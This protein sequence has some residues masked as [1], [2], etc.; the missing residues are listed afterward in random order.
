MAV[1]KNKI[2]AEATKHVQK[3]AFDKAIHAYR[4]ILAADAK[5]VRV[6]LKVAELQQKKGDARAAVEAYDKVAQTYAEQGFF[7]KAVAVYK[8]IVKLAPDDVRVN[9]QLAAL[10]QQLG[11]MSDAMAQFQAMAAAY[12]KA[13]D[14]A[15]LTDVLKRMVELDPENIASSIKLGEL[16]AR[17]RQTA[18]ALECFRRAAD[19]LKKHNRADEYVKVADRIAALSPDDFGLARELANIYL[20]KGDTKRAL[21]KLQLCFKADPKDVDTLHLLAQA[22]RDLGQISKTLSVYKELARVHEDR[23]RPQEAQA[24]WRKVQE[25]SPADEDALAALGSAART[26]RPPH[27]VAPAR[28]APSAAPPAAR[29]PPPPI[30][31][32][33]RPPPARPAPAPVDAPPP[34][35]GSEVIPKLM[36]ETDVYVKYG[37]IPK[38]L[39]HLQKLLAIDPGYAPAHEKARELHLSAG[40]EQEAAEAGARAVRAFAARGDLDRAREAVSRLAQIAPDWPELGALSAAVG[41]TEEVDLAVEGEEVVIVAGDVA[42]EPDLDDDAL[43]LAAAAAGDEE[44]IDEEVVVD[45][46]ASEAQEAPAPSV[47]GAP[48]PPAPAPPRAAAP[49]AAPRGAPSRPARAAPEPEREPEPDDEEVDLSDE[50]EEADFFVQQGLLDDAREAL[51]NLLAFYPRHSVLEAKLAE[52]ERRGRAAPAQAPPPAEAAD[53]SF[54]IARELAEMGGGSAA[55][56]EE[57]FQYSVED[58]FNQFKKGIEQTVKAEDSATHYDLGIAYKEMGLVD[59]AIHEFETALAGKD[60][61]REVDCLSMIGLCHLSK[62]DGAGAIAAFRRAL[63]S[64]RLTRDAAKAIHFDLAAAYEERGD[65]E[66]A[67]YYFQRVAKADA[68]FRAVAERVAALG[69]GAGRAPPDDQPRAPAASGGRSPPPQIPRASPGKKNIGYL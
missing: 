1:D 3:G 62:G 15:R 11:L 16:Y 59:D 9:E 29:P 64:D 41:G 6:L 37:L 48:P 21:A 60:R 40:H 45:E 8:Q 44:V 28:G 26:A 27:P 68:A 10:Y 22:F 14:G 7:L 57:E 33:V 34:S 25:F 69:G 13:G 49:P 55:P 2:I 54:D 43:A 17:A 67:L 18:P 61:R 47:R 32:A 19:Y 35:A 12:E 52:I 31:G 38:A 51:Q 66:A 23:G 58:V 42:E 56:A 39:D 65:G 50:I 20:A 46:E 4:R 24:T 53:G 30:P 5:D 63:A 36:T